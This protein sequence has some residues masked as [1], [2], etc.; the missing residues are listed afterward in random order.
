MTSF[1]IPLKSI[2][3]YEQ[4]ITIYYEKLVEKQAL[5]AMLYEEECDQ[6]KATEGS[7]DVPHKDEEQVNLDV[8]RSFNSFPKNIDE[9]DKEKLQTHLKNVIV[10]VLR[11]YP[12]LHY[13]QVSRT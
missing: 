13:Y 1:K 9:E 10:H 11:S 4:K 7:L 5:V 6:N 3:P 8:I 2:K 12:S